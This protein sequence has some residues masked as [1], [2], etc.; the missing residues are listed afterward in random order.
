ML[1][2]LQVSIRRELRPVTSPPFLTGAALSR[3]ARA[4]EQC[5]TREY[6]DSVQAAVVAELQDGLVE[7]F[8]DVIEEYQDD[9]E[10]LIECK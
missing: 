5:C 6:I 10:N 2:P 4:D 7:E 3:C 1:W 9:V 8:A